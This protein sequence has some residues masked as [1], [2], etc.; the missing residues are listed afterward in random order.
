MEHARPSS[1][2][3]FIPRPDG[4]VRVFVASI[5]AVVV[6]CGNTSA[7]PKP[8]PPIMKEKLTNAEALVEAVVR[9]DFAAMSRYGDRLGQI[10]W[11]EIVSWQKAEPEY[12]RY[13]RSFLQAVDAFRVA[14]SAKDYDAASAGYT[15]MLSACTGCHS[16]RRRADR[17]SASP[18]P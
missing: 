6:T 9:G 15:R 8:L 11:A 10:T 3:G 12:L 16:Y 14:V 17:V 5:V 1:M 7:Q 2:S 18:T 4:V 13:G